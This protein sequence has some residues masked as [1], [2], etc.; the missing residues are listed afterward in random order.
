MSSLQD[1]LRD[2]TFP[3]RTRI[4]THLTHKN[5]M[6]IQF[7][8]ILHSTIISSDINISNTFVS[9]ILATKQLAARLETK[10]AHVFAFLQLLF[11]EFARTVFC[12]SWTKFWEGFISDFVLCHSS[13]GIYTIQNLQVENIK[14]NL[15][16]TICIVGGWE[17]ITMC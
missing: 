13:Y 6:R 12:L 17:K 11:R 14:Q 9:G 7:L 4:K 2:I 16:E 15:W 10:R 1:H 5:Y 8:K 3:P